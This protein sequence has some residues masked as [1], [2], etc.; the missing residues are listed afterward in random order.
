MA[1]ITEVVIKAGKH[2]FELSLEE[3]KGLRDVLNSTFP[4]KQKEYIPHPSPVI[5]ERYPYPCGPY[6]TAWCANDAAANE[7]T[8]YISSSFSE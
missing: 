1:Q 7:T 2:E 8:I 5:I 3:A 6:W 4:E